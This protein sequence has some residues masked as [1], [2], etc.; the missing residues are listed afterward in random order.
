MP[1]DVEVQSLESAATTFT[2]YTARALTDPH[3]RLVALSGIAQT[4]DSVHTNSN[5]E[6]PSMECSSDCYGAGTWATLDVAQLLWRIPSDVA[7]HRTE[8][9]VAPS[10]S[11]AAMEGPVSFHFVDQSGSL[12]LPSCLKATVK[13]CKIYQAS[14]VA[15]FGRIL[16]ESYV[17]ISSAVRRLPDYS[18]VCN[19]AQDALKLL[20][21]EFGLR[22]LPDTREDETDI[23]NAV[24]GGP[25]IWALEILPPVAM[26]F[27]GAKGLLWTRNDSGSF[28]R[29]GL[30]AFT[31]DFLQVFSDEVASFFDGIAAEIVTI[32]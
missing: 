9:Y 5:S 11:W 19:T 31:D 12:H 15:P 3:D 14:T 10:W 18:D 32:V 17:N 2:V 4:L 22:L 21:Q 13:K 24:I 8:T 7:T 1:A 23:A 28:R 20:G 26:D 6:S 16:T 29:I 30:Y 27:S 25:S